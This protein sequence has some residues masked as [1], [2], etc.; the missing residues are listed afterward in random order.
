MSEGT[1]DPK[2]IPVRSQP[3]GWMGLGLLFQRLSPF[4]FDISRTEPQLPDYVH[5]SM[6]YSVWEGALAGIFAVFIGGVLLTGFALSLGANEFV[7]GLIAAIQA[8][9]NLM[10]L[11]AFRLL[12]RRGNRKRMSVVFAAASR[13]VWVPICVVVFLT[14]EPIAS[15]RIW[16]F[17][18]LFALSAVLGIFSLVP[19]ISWLVDLVPQRVRG[20]FFAQR[21]LAGGA[22]GIL[23][24]IAAGKFIDLWKEHHIGPDSYGFVV[25]IAFGMI[26]G[27]W[28]VVMQNKMHEPPFPKPEIQPS[29]WESI[30]IPFQDENFRQLFRF[31]IFY[32]ISMGIA[33]AFYGVY[34]LEQAKLSFTFV[35]TM[36]MLSTLTNLL[37]L[38]PWGKVLDKYGNKP[39]L[40]ICIIG[41]MIF[42]LLWVFTSPGTIWLYVLIHLFG[43]FDGGNTIA[44]PNLIY[45]I[46]PPDKRA[47]YIAVDGTVVGVAATIAPLVG[48]GLAIL[49]SHWQLDLGWLRLEHLH[50]LFLTAAILRIGTFF[51]LNNV[52]EPESKSVTHVIKVIVPIRG[53][54]IFEGFQEALHSLLAPARYVLDKLV[55]R[56]RRKRRRK[57]EETKRKQK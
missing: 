46:A 50:F 16:I 7:I 47:N 14:L 41:K 42:A 5:R 40:G 8:G 38:K 13:L 6:Q 9:A 4:H 29:Y 44:I 22:V 33:G 39:I 25:L 57:K 19:W 54:D 36:A 45:K 34:M 26:F 31:R 3:R 52:T 53:V 18:A 43:V 12:E 37:S 32:D 48:G 2:S 51:F 21:N 49:Y 55:E 24:G 10:Q 11:R 20:R 15:Y 30:R 1:N 17:V 56:P 27:L 23:L 28:A 35:A